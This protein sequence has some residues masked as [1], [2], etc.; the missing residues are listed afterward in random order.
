VRIEPAVQQHLP[1]ADTVAAAAATFLVAATQ[2]QRC[3]GLAV[4]M[5][6][7]IRVTAPCG[8]TRRD[9]RKAAHEWRDQRR[10]LTRGAFIRRSDTARP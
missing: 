7:Q 4:A 9:L 6:G 2:Y 1:A 10:V 3:I 5:A 8:F